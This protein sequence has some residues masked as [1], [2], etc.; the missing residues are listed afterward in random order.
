MDNIESHLA[1]ILQ[2]RA[3]IDFKANINYRDEKLLGQ[4][5]GMPARELLLTL[6][7]IEKEFS[8][9]IPEQSITNGSFDTYNHILKIIRESFG[10]ERKK[11]RRN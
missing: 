11:E 9:K 10:N 5:I 8:I 2:K 6:F 7:D 3:H 1:V 4:T